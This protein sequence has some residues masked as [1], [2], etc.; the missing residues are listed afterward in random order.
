MRRSFGIN[1]NMQ[2][3]LIIAVSASFFDFFQN[4]LTLYLLSCVISGKIVFLRKAP[5]K[6]PL[7]RVIS[8]GIFHLYI[9][10]LQKGVGNTVSNTL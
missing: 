1:V 9:K 5:S 2:Q 3:A 8:E 4:H 10:N 6:C 7:K